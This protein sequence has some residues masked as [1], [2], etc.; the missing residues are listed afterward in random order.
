MLSFSL[1]TVLLR[2]LFFPTF[3]QCD[4]PLLLQELH[5]VTPLFAR[6]LFFFRVT[7]LDDIHMKNLGRNAKFL[8]REIL[9]V[10]IFY[11]LFLFLQFDVTASPQAMITFC[12]YIYFYFVSASYQ[13]ASL[14]HRV[15][16]RSESNALVRWERVA[17]RN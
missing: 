1:T 6:A 5:S 14:D 17:C 7:A 8:F 4:C 13:L 9:C 12:R 11:C 3:G 10:Q 16:L 15:V 2:E